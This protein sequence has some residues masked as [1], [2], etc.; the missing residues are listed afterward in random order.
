MVWRYKRKEN[1]KPIYKKF[2]GKVMESKTDTMEFPNTDW[3]SLDARTVVQAAHDKYPGWTLGGY[4][5]YKE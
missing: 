2:G 5:E 3:E 1:G 4:C